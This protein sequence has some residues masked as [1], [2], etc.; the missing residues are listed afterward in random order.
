MALHTTLM[1]LFYGES[2]WIVSRIS[3]CF[4]GQDGVERFYLRAVEH[5]TA[6]SCLEE[7]SVEVSILQ[8]VKYL[9]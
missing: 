8:S 2:Q 4:S 1:T 5:V 7:H 6:R 3:A 9:D